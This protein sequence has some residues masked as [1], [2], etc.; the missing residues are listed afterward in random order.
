MEW[1]IRSADNVF[2]RDKGNNPVLSGESAVEVSRVPNIR[3]ERY[4]AGSPGGIRAATS[5]E[6]A[7]FDAAQR[8]AEANGA[9]W[10][11]LDYAVRAIVQL[12]LEERQK[13]VT[14]DG[15]TL[16]TMNECLLRIRAIYRALLDA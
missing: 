6:L 11:R 8:D 3:T 7:D 2:V 15:Q 12:D 9:A 5:Q 4:D 14:K 1:V 10:R 16:R 13:L